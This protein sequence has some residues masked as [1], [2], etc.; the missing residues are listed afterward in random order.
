M[1]TRFHS[2]ESTK[3]LKS[4]LCCTP[5]LHYV[6]KQVLLL[7]LLLSFATFSIKLYIFKRMDAIGRFLPYFYLRILF[8]DFVCFPVHRSPSEKGSTQE[9]K[10]P[11]ENFFFFS[12]LFQNRPLLPGDPKIT[13]TALT[14]VFS[15][16]SSQV[17]CSCKIMI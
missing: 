15:L 7:F 14:V 9:G 6:Y 12:F 13:L 1:M 4:L 8:C 16:K 3:F 17:F 10:L 11:R 5:L 2:P